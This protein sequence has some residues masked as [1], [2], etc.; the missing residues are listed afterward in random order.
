[1][2]ILFTGVSSFTGYWFVKILAEA[3]YYV[4]ATL[5]NAKETYAG[6]KKQRIEAIE[7]HCQ[8][9]ENCKFGSAEFLSLI[10]SQHWDFLCH[11]AADVRDYRNPQ[12]NVVAALEN[13]THNLRTVLERLK[14]QSCQK[15]ILT[16]SVFE[17]NEGAGQVPLHAFSPYGLSKG[18][19]ADF[20]KYYCQ[21]VNMQLG[22]FVIPNPFGPFEEQRFTAYLMRQWFEGKI[23]TVSSPAYVRDN[24]HVR[25]LAKAYLYFIQNFPKITEFHP[26]GYVESQGAFTQR[27]AREMEKRL[28]MPCQ[29]ELHQQMEFPEPIVRINTDPLSGLKLDWQESQDWDA[30]AEYYQGIYQLSAKSS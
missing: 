17:Q 11:H 9:I 8:I 22:K 18:L 5:Q 4:T 7:N 12:F 15:V 27:F 19:T 30:I 1:M 13:N 20:F 28:E 14:E 25:L 26:S 6:L 24:I 29:Y 21:T 3:G 10:Q 23:A 16:G 2:N